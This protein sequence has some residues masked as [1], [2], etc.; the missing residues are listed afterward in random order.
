MPGVVSGPVQ[1]ETDDYLV[2]GGFPPGLNTADPVTALKADES[3]EAYGIG[4]SVDGVLSTG[5][6]PSGTS[7]IQKTTSFTFQSATVP[8]LWIYNR[9]WN[10]TGLTASTASNIL[11]YGAP[12][13]DDAYFDQAGGKIPLDDDAQ[14]IVA[15]VPFGGDSL[16]VAKSTGSYIIGNCTD[17]RAFFQKSGIKQELA[18]STSTMVLALDDVLYASNATGLIAFQNGQSVDVTEKVRNDKT[19]F[20]SQA[21]TADFVKKRVIGTSFVYDAT[22]KKLFYYSGSSFRF[23]SRQF[24]LPD[25]TPFAADGMLVTVQHGSTA[26]GSFSYQLKVEDD[27]WQDAIT[28]PVQYDQEKFT[29]VREGFQNAVSCTRIQIR[30]TALSSNIYIK[31]IRLDARRF[32]RDDYKR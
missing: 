32:Q 4:L 6:I 24:H 29:I 19:N 7:R 13:V 31:E 8:F 5:S 9:L 1:F 12:M 2:A 17:T 26:G 20:A 30:L 28:V 14:T 15:L 3:P 22:L 23:T 16:C 10:I 21:L 11:R 25:W 18:V 27:A